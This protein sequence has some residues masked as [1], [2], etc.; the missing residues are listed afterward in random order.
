MGA[1]LFP[2]SERSL[3]QRQNPSILVTVTMQGNMQGAVAV[4]VD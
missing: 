1:Y 4:Q 2:G 3:L